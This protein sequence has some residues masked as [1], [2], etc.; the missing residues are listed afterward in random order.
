MRKI[1]SFLPQSILYLILYFPV[2]LSSCEKVKD[3][4]TVAGQGP[5]QIITGTFTFTGT[6]NTGTSRCYSDPSN[7]TGTG[8]ASSV[9][10]STSGYYKNVIIGNMPVSGSV[11]VSDKYDRI[12]CYSCPVI[13]VT[14]GSLSATDSYESYSGTITKTATG[15]SFSASMIRI[16]DIG[17]S[18][19]QKFTL[20][21][22]LNCQ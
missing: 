16:Q 14:Y 4:E 19:P 15:Y 6:T 11:T 10:A 9:D 5:S 8:L 22:S 18:N 12:G 13:F 2:L 17:S 7:F 21:G 3:A 1:M 20:T